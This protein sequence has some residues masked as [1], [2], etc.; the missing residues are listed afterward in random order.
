MQASPVRLKA[1]LLSR[2]VL[3]K[4]GLAFVSLASLV[5]MTLTTLRQGAWAVDVIAMRWLGL[6]LPAMLVGAWV[7]QRFLLQ[8]AVRLRP[9]DAAVAYAEAMNRRFYRLQAWAVPLLAV[10]LIFNLFYYRGIAV[11]QGWA[12]VLTPWLWAAGG[13]LAV[14]GLVYGAYYAGR[15]AEAGWAGRFLLSGV[16]LVV[17]LSA[18]SVLAQVGG[19]FHWLQF[20]ARVLHLL[21]FSVWFG[22]AVWNIFIAVPEGQKRVSLDTVI[23][24]NVM[25]E[26]FRVLVR[27]VFPV[28]IVTGLIQATFVI[29]FDLSLLFT[30]LAGNLVLT[31]LLMI[32]A[33]VVI[34]ILCPMWRACSPVSGVCNLDDLDLE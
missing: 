30:T 27:C 31:K 28:I 3:P 17:V 4:V 34:F 7:W 12:D 26:R 33:L 22:G 24:A 13:I 8:P 20:S 32:A 15:R 18:L 23:L 11:Q 19:Y 16:A 14:L 21:A 9:V 25:L 6:V 29:G 1:Q 10:T 2:F 5:G